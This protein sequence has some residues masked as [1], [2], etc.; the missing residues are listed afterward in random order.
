MT[1]RAWLAAAALAAAGAPMLTISGNVGTDALV[2]LSI[3]SRNLAVTT[4]GASGAFLFAGLDPGTYV[5]TPS[6]RDCV[7][8]PAARAVTLSGADVSGVTFRSSCP[9]PDPPG[10]G[11]KQ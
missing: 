3:G 9:A 8:T 4:A 7:F 5:I 1:R 11:R 6:K 10:K 2:Q